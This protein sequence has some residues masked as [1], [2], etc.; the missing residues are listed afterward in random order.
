[1]GTCSDEVSVGL[2]LPEFNSEN[3][4]LFCDR[5]LQSDESESFIVLVTRTCDLNC[6]KYGT[7]NM[8]SSGF[9]VYEIVR[10][11]G[12]DALSAIILKASSE[13]LVEGLEIPSRDTLGDGSVVTVP[14]RNY[15]SRYI[16]N[17]SVGGEFELDICCLRP[18]RALKCLFGKSFSC[19]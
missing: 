4:T 7:L 3:V 1:M 18:D 17:F 14:C 19:K 10:G 6:I 13:Y 16:L 5:L 8:Q 12:D 9:R 2:W 15:D 11:I